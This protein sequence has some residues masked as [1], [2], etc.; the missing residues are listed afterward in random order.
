[1]LLAI[2]NSTQAAKFVAKISS[3]SKQL[4]LRVLSLEEIVVKDIKLLEIIAEA[5]ITKGLDN[6]YFE[7]IANIRVAEI[8]SEDHAYRLHMDSQNFCPLIVTLGFTE[9]NSFIIKIQ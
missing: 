6:M 8:K 3:N 1:M 2:T 4:A 5:K 9:K 7:D